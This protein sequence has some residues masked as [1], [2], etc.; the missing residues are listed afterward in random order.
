MAAS[1]EPSDEILTH[2]FVHVND[3][4][5]PVQIKLENLDELNNLEINLGIKCRGCFTEDPEM[6]YMFTVID[7]KFN[8]ADILGQTTSYII[9]EGDGFPPYLCTKCT[10]CLVDF[11]NFKIQF[12]KTNLYI[13]TLL[14][15]PTEICSPLNNIQSESEIYAESDIESNYKKVDRTNE[16][17]IPDITEIQGQVTSFCNACN[18][19]FK[20][21]DEYDTHMAREHGENPFE[22]YALFRKLFEKNRMAQMK[23]QKKLKHARVDREEIK[24]F[25]MPGRL[26]RLC[27]RKFPEEEFRAHWEKHKNQICEHCGHK[28][29]KKSDLDVHKQSV[30]STERNFECQICNKRFKTKQLLNRHGVV[31]TNPRSHV[32]H[33][34]GDRFND[35]STLNT[36]IQLKHIRSRDFV[37]SICGLAFPMKPTLEKHI[38]RHNKERPPTFFCSLCNAG[39]KDKSSL[40]RHHLMKH[41]DNYERPQCHFCEKRYSSNAK[42]RFHIERHHSGV[43]YERKKKKGSIKLEIKRPYFVGIS[44]NE[45]T[46]SSGNE[47]NENMDVV[48]NLFSEYSYPAQRTDHFMRNDQIEKGIM[49]ESD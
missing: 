30:H 25:Q 19:E 33:Q 7:E 15:K 35:R 31:H 46:S 2:H 24:L 22:K 12:E 20:T 32:C 40:K 27:Q 28:F 3:C 8:L 49:L 6:H 36:H 41:T 48:Q 17:S 34:C 13:R 10:N 9:K 11:Y 42:L 29:V 5:D 14:C 26:C 16:I 43:K 21:R 1:N 18:L 37:C 45:D 44:K 38:L 23:E 47:C 39:F 4:L